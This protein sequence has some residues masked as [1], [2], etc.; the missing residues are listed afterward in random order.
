MDTTPPI[1]QKLIDDLGINGFPQDAQDAIVTRLGETIL[2]R[3][4]VD[5]LER[6]IDADRE[7]FA[8]ITDDENSD[9]NTINTFLRERIPDLDV[10]TLSAAEQEVALL[11]QSMGEMAI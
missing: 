3:L 2:K 11:K 7:E 5:V 1:P 6:L 4:M 9:W 8:K 10:L